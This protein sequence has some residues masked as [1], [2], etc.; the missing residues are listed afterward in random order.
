M[1]QNNLKGRLGLLALIGLELIGATVVLWW[2]S[3]LA[4]EP[5]DLQRRP[6]DFHAQGPRSQPISVWMADGLPPDVERAVRGWLDR[7]PGGWTWAEPSAADLTLDWQK[8]ATARPLAEIVLAPVAPFLTLRQE[9]TLHELRRAWSE[10]SDPR[11][12]ISHLFISSETLG[13]LAAI[14]GA[15]GDHASLSVIPAQELTTQLEATPNAVGIV[16]FERLDPRLKALTLEGQSVLDRTMDLGRYPLRVPVWIDGPPELTRDLALEVEEKGLTSNRHPEHLTEVMMTGVTALTRH[17]AV[18][19]EA[20]NDY[21]WP[22]RRIARFLAAAD[23]THISNEVSF[24]AH[25]Q[26]QAE[27]QVFCAKPEY[28]ETL[29]LVGADLVELTGNHNLDCGPGYALQSLDLYAEA[30]MHTYGGGRNAADARKPLL[31]THQGNR[32]AFLGYNQFG[33][34]YAWAGEDRPGAAP[35]SLSAVQADLAQIRNQA[36][37]I[38]VTVQ[39]T[40]AYQPT[41]L[42][43]QVA[44]FRAVIEAGADVVIGSQA[45]Q[46][47]AVEFYGDGLILYG[48]GNLFFDQLWSEATRQS[49][50]ARHI[51]YKG[52]LI[53]VQLI[54]TVMDNRYQAHFGNAQEQQTILQTVF[55]ASSW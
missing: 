44:D 25:C 21:G 51:I 19:M 40:E 29:R 9:I 4:R 13:P 50:I 28:L 11:R 17:L 20:R 30:G 7:Q 45:H 42:P 31:L 5:N 53:S 33:P 34:E 6:A 16:P 14:W 27:T 52:R 22:A 24:V 1:D 41:P 36:D 2:A 15:P 37:V 23:L 49:L 35:F 48:L 39:H 8:G 55:Q 32:L 3:G 38:F 46:P 18:E 10:P 26:A 54:P 43:E 47:Q 12:T